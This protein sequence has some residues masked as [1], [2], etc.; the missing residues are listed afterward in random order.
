MVDINDNKWYE[1]YKTVRNEI[2]KYSE[3]VS[4]KEEIIVFTKVDLLDKK[5]RRK[6]LD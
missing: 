2:S 1:N 5:F 3:K 6:K 4:S